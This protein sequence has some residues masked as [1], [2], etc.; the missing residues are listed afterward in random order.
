MTESNGRTDGG[1]ACP[2]CGASVDTP[3]CPHCGSRTVPADQPVWSARSAAAAISDNASTAPLVPVAPQDA[4]PRAVPEMFPT[5]LV[6]TAGTGQAWSQ[7]PELPANAAAPQSGLFPGWTGM[8]PSVATAGA[9][10]ALAPRPERRRKAIYA[11]AGIAAAT[12]LVLLAALLVSPHLGGGSGVADKDG[13]PVAL[14]SPPLSTAASVPVQSGDPGPATQSL[15]GP[16]PSTAVTITRTP[17]GG[18]TPTGNAKQTGSARALGTTAAA[19]PSAATPSRPKAVPPKTTRKKPAPAK[20]AAAPLGVPARNI[21]CSGGYIVQLASDVSAA[22][23][24]AH[25]ARLKAGGQLP[26]GSLAADST[27]SC[28]LFSSQINTVVLYAG[29]FA[30]KYAGCATRLSGPADAYIKGGNPEHAR[31]Y[32]SCLCPAHTNKLPKFSHIGQQNVWVGELQRMLGNRLNIPIGDLT[33]RWGI[34]TPDTKRAVQSFQRS[35]HLPANGAVDSR[36]WKRLQSA[37]C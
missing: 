20:A 4:P 10:G 2:G 27:H 8:Y 23:F 32:I 6:P 30:S 11:V 17:T 31:D 24:A 29:P 1:R 5:E 13:Q 7:A 26:A 28:K 18:P 3:Y 21:A 9:K 37:G 34:Y 22:A 33:G 19:K 14:I 36:T 16:V 12:V 25:V 35:Q 15:P